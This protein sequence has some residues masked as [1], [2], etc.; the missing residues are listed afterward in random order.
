MSVLHATG[1]A[2]HPEEVAEIID[3]PLKND[4]LT[5]L[6]LA[7]KPQKRCNFAPDAGP[8]DDGDLP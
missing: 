4:E 1:S 2:C 8:A 5:D 3:D 6:S 7:I